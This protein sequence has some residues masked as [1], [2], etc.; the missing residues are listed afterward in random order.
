MKLHYI[1]PSAEEFR[2]LIE[3]NILTVSGNP[4]QGG[5]ESIGGYEDLP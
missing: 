1:Q 4:P 2:L 3:N 5:S